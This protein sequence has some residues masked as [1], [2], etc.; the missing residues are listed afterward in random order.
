MALIRTSYD[1]IRFVWWLK[2][3]L[4]ARLLQDPGAI[5][6]LVEEPEGNL[7]MHVL[8]VPFYV[9]GGP[10]DLAVP[11]Y[12]RAVSKGNRMINLPLWLKMYSPIFAS[13]ANLKLASL[14]SR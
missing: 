13:E 2:F 1:L 3:F 11:T 8:L 14:G 5:L 4:F 10:L 7:A 6:F 9:M 12:D